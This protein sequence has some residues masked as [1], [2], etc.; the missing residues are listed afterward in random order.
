LD[1]ETDFNYHIH[2]N[3]PSAAFRSICIRLTR[4]LLTMGG[5]YQHCPSDCGM[6]VALMMALF[7]LM[8]RRDSGGVDSCKLLIYSAKYDP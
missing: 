4:F 6:N 5:I 1:L 3:L 7:I 2:S 8:E